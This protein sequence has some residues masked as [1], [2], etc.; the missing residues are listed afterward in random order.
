[1]ECRWPKPSSDAARSCWMMEA[2]AAHATALPLRLPLPFPF[3]AQAPTRVKL[4]WPICQRACQE[5]LSR[6]LR[7][8]LSTCLSHLTPDDGVTA[9]CLDPFLL[10]CS[11]DTGLS[12]TLP[13]P[14]SPSPYPLHL[15]L[16]IRPTI[17]VSS[18]FPISTFFLLTFLHLS[19]VGLSDTVSFSF[20]RSKHLQH[21]HQLDLVLVRSF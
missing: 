3:L 15:F 9:A 6:P 19:S 20:P 4:S 18:S 1:M 13:L 8:S 12:H 14:P 2:A 10:S 17:S 7:L 21:Q 11:A 16:S 5:L